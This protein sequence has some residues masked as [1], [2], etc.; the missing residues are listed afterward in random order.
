MRIRDA[1]RGRGR[2]GAESLSSGMGAVVRD[3]VGESGIG[4]DC[5]SEIQM[6]KMKG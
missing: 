4:V 1:E 6:L 3:G 5:E 2:A